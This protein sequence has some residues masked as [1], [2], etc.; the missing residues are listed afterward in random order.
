[1]SIAKNSKE[2]HEDEVRLILEKLEKRLDVSIS[3]DY[4]FCNEGRLFVWT[5]DDDSDFLGLY[6][7]D[8]N[9]IQDLTTFF[10]DLLDD[11]NDVDSLISFTDVVT[12][13]NCNTEVRKKDCDGTDEDEI[14]SALSRIEWDLGLDIR[15]HNFSRNKG[16]L[17]IFIK[18][19]DRL[20]GIEDF[21]LDDVQDLE[22][23]FTDLLENYD[24]A[25]EF[26]DESIGA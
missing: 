15:I 2:Y 3:L 5:S 10:M 18:D 12:D 1:M 24:C 7:F 17:I 6:D 21:Y 26:M 19:S 25:A 13:Y 8:L 16:R 20:L 11:Y 22:E 14:E 23:Y 4:F 9:G